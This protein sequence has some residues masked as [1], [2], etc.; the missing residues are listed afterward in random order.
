MH[1]VGVRH[2]Q[3]LVGLAAAQRDRKQQIVVVDAAVAGVVERREVLHQLDAALLEH[4]QP[5]FGVDALDLA[6]ELECVCAPRTSVALSTI[7]NR[8]C[9]VSCGMRNEAPSWHA[10][11]RQLRHRCVSG[12][13]LLKKVLTLT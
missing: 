1:V 12:S 3:S 2:D 9:C 11:E 6:A 10:R 13:V 5:E 4:A 7:C 8:V